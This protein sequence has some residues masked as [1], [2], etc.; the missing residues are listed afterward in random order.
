MIALCIELSENIKDGEDLVKVAQQWIK[1]VQ[2]RS[3]TFKP[4]EQIE[5]GAVRKGH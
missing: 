3:H 1:E 2:V 5:N 4:P